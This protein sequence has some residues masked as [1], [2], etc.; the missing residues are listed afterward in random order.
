MAPDWCVKIICLVRGHAW[1]VPSTDRST[2]MAKRPWSRK[3]EDFTKVRCTRCCGTYYRR[4]NARTQ[5]G[6]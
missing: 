1:D 6:L 3:A 4:G 2:H 5:R